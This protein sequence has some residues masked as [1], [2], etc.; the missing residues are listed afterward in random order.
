MRFPLPWASATREERLIALKEAFPTDPN[1]NKCEGMRDILQYLHNLKFSE[2]PDYK[3]IYNCLMEVIKKRKWK[4]SEPYDWEASLSSKKVEEPLKKKSEPKKSTPQLPTITVSG[5]H[6]IPPLVPPG[7][8]AVAENTTPSTSITDS[9]YSNKSDGN[10][11]NNS[12]KQAADAREI[13]TAI[14]PPTKDQQPQKQQPSDPLAQL[15][16]STAREESIKI[17]KEPKEPS[18]KK[19]KGSKRKKN[20]EEDGGGAPPPP[21]AITIPPLTSPSST[22]PSTL[23]A[24]SKKKKDAQNNNDG[25]QKKKKASSLKLH[26]REQPQPNLQSPV[27]AQSPNTGSGGGGAVSP[28]SPSTKPAEKSLYMEYSKLNKKDKSEIKEPILGEEDLFPTTA[29]GAF[30]FKPGDIP[31][32]SSVQENKQSTLKSV[33]STYAPL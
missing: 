20:N 6:E 9:N 29:P 17:K 28:V 1:L 24:S 27:T 4:F 10:P 25:S 8:P 30:D 22:S 15:E 19:K 31:S 11:Q 26:N 16:E 33:I 32:G 21:P 5:E 23:N 2:R 18:E 7:A 14:P 13:Q 3:F 12:N